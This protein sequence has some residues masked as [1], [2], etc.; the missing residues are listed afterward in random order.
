LPAS[1]IPVS[2]KPPLKPQNEIQTQSA[3]SIIETIT[4]RTSINDFTT[5]VNNVNQF[6]DQSDHYQVEMSYWKTLG[7]SGTALHRAAHVDNPSLITHIVIDLGKHS[8]LELGDRPGHTPLLI[9]AREVHVKAVEALIAAKA[10]PN[11][12]ALPPS[13]RSYL[14]TPVMEVAKKISH[15]EDNLYGLV[16]GRKRAEKNNYEN[17]QGYSAAEY[18][19]AI[20]CENSKIAKCKMIMQSLIRVGGIWCDQDDLD[21]DLIKTRRF[22]DEE[23]T[24]IMERRKTL[25]PVIFTATHGII[26]S[27]LCPL[28]ADYDSFIVSPPLLA[29]LP[30]SSS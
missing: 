7:P 29:A 8:L 28:I 13:F 23:R 16:S 6:V 9:A 25:P 2:K 20:E 10:N 19:A 17:H 5:M 21:E 22:Y 27:V 14:L 18:E 11:T 12:S 26:L 30:P 15:S 3:N 24:N 4:E 1:Q